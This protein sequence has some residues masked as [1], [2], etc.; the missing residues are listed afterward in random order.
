MPTF[1]SESIHND[2]EIKKEIKIESFEGI[3]KCQLF[4][5][6]TKSIQG[7]ENSNHYGS[8]KLHEQD[9]R[10]SQDESENLKLLN[11]KI[12]EE[13]IEF[14]EMPIFERDSTYLEERIKKEIKT[15]PLW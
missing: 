7:A 9:C 6:R 1:E 11:T 15:E 5:N 13:P 4:D 10:T 14:D 12:K 2:M 8:T 3:E